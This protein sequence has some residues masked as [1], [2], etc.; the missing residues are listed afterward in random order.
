MLVENKVRH[1]AAAVD[2][3]MQALAHLAADGAVS[4]EGVLVHVDLPPDAAVVAAAVGDAVKAL[5]I[6]RTNILHGGVLPVPVSRDAW[7]RV[8]LYYKTV[9]RALQ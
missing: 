3:F 8:P 1:L 6:I 5:I 9:Q 7:D 2:T 4:S